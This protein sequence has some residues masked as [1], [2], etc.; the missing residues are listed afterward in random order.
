[1]LASA[2]KDSDAV[3][4]DVGDYLSL[5]ATN[6]QIRQTAVNWLF[7]GVTQIA[8][9]ANRRSIPIAVERADPHRFDYKG[10]NIVG[11]LV[12]LKQGVRSLLIEAGWTRTPG[13]GFMRGG[14]MAVARI[15]H[16]GM[17]DAGADLILIRH[18]GTP[19]WCSLDKSETRVEFHAR[20]LMR[21]FAIFIGEP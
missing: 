15:S 9:E 6:D 16:F 7:E 4:R 2:A 21:H 17:K 18:E 10:A 8:A 11:S 14:A 5:K 13:D 12:R 19:I 20:E 1:M 3:G